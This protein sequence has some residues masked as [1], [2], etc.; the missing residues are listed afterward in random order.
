MKT[1]GITLLIIGLA[2]TIFTTFKFF[3]KEK[4]ADLGNIEI[5]TEKPHSLSWS[6]LYGLAVMCIGGIALGQG[7][8]KKIRVKHLYFQKSWIE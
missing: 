3:T 6:P 2:L 8:K 1:A 5:S 4:V 7:S